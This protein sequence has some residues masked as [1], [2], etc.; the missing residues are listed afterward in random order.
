MCV[1]FKKTRFYFTSSYF[2]KNYYD[3]MNMAKDA[4]FTMLGWS[5]TFS[6]YRD[7][8]KVENFFLLT[9]VVQKFIQKLKKYQTKELL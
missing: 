3:Y 9:C 4:H 7:H 1:I 2:A 5:F 8:M 6:N